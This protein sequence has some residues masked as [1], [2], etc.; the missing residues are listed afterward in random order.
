[1]SVD[2]KAASFI[3]VVRDGGQ[4]PKLA[5]CETINLSHNVAASD[6]VFKKWARGLELSNLP[7]TTVLDAS[8][9]RLLTTEAPNVPA[10][11]LR[12]ALR[13]KIKDLIDFP[14][15]EAT[16]DVFDIPGAQAEDSG[17]PVYVVAARNDAIR[18]RVAMLTSVKANLKFIDVVEMSLRNIAGLL[19]EDQAG[20]AMLSLYEN[21]GLIT[22]TKQSKLYLT[23][24]LNVGLE[25]MT[26]PQLNV[27][28]FNQ[29][30]LELQRSLDYFESHFRQPAI[31]HVF[32]APLE[33]EVPGLLNFLQTNLG[34]AAAYVNLESILDC[35][36]K[37]PLGW[38]A[39]HYIAVG[40]A[41]R[42]EI[43]A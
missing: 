43:A 12:A 31:R 33:T 35:S 26:H 37:L 17:R 38:Q 10:E 13:W 40:A 9:Y 20:V 41:L 14:I 27:G 32:I 15:Q 28:A 8:Q 11:E 30:A 36:L 5:A 4:R 3:R 7:C 42:Q 21:S 16:I 29:V 25:N 23:R 24:S 6:S 2:A 1:M 19:P 22:L 39:K 34:I 18:S